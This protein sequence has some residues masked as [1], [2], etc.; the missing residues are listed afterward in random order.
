MTIPGNI[1]LKVV[2]SFAHAQIN[3]LWRHNGRMIAD[4][5]NKREILRAERDG[6]DNF[7][8]IQLSKQNGS[9]F[10]FPLLVFISL[11]QAQTKADWPI[12]RTTLHD[13]AKFYPLPVFLG[14]SLTNF[15]H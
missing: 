2:F 3:T 6:N 4:A 1:N 13:R 7:S 12:M 8:I 9:I 10:K 11:G 5:C 15:G 14:S